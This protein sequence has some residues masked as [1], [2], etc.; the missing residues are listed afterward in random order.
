VLYITASKTSAGDQLRVYNGIYLSQAKLGHAERASA[1][2][3][4]L[5]Q[6]GPRKKRLA[7]KFLFQ[8]GSVRFA[9]DAKLSNTYGLWLSRSPR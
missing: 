7:V 8:P 9:A 2:F 1:A 6:Y 5:V 3:R 4:D